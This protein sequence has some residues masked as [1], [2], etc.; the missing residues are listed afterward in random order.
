MP[1]TIKISVLTCSDVKPDQAPRVRADSFTF[2][3]GKILQLMVVLVGHPEVQ[4]SSRHC[5]AFQF[6]GWVF[7]PLLPSPTSAHGAGAS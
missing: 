4:L 1:L 3:L 6:H 2:A 5:R 7:A